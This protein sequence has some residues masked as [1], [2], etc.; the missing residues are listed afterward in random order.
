MPHEGGHLHVWEKSW[1]T[2]PINHFQRDEERTCWLPTPL[3]DELWPEEAPLLSDEEFDTLLESVPPAMSHGMVTTWQNPPL[4]MTRQTKPYI[5]IAIDTPLRCRVSRIL[6]EDRLTVDMPLRSRNQLTRARRL[7]E[8]ALADALPASINQ[9]DELVRRIPPDDTLAEFEMPDDNL[10]IQ[11]GRDN[12][13][14]AWLSLRQGEQAMRRLAIWTDGDGFLG[15]CNLS[16]PIALWG[17]NTSDERFTGEAWTAELRQ[18]W[19]N[20]INQFLADVP[21]QRQPAKKSGKA[22]AALTK[23]EMTRLCELLAPTL[24]GKERSAMVSALNQAQT[25]APDP[26]LADTRWGQPGAQLWEELLDQLEN[27]GLLHGFDKQ[28]PLDATDACNALAQRA[29]IDEHYTPSDDCGNDSFFDVAQDFTRWLAPRNYT[30]LWPQGSLRW[31]GDDIFP[32]VIT[33]TANTD[34]IDQLVGKLG[35]YP[36]FTR[37]P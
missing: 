18:Q 19:R 29:G 7:F 1:S 16:G 36:R 23:K 20:A 28:Q 9:L 3:E 30:L 27:H 26:D 34:E 10:Q 17:A 33:P 5:S 8:R 22:Q 25:A 12:L 24:S 4:S 31:D 37:T 2:K 14:G 21:A 6:G 11:D 13:R 15:G 32:A 35:G